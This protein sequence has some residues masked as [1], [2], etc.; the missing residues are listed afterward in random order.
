MTEQDVLFQTEKE[1]LD[2]ER[3]ANVEAMHTYL[4]SLEGCPFCG[5]PESSVLS[6]VRNHLMTHALPDFHDGSGCMR[7]HLLG[8][9]ARYYAKN[10]DGHWLD[11]YG[12]ITRFRDKAI[13]W[14]ADWFAEV[15]ADLKAAGVLDD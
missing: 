2:D 8:N 9:Q 4:E 11:R 5:Y 1:Q 12:E 7:L 6:Y 10:N 15:E 13:N 3:K 14:P